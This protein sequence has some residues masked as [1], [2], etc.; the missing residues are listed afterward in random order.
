MSDYILYQQFGGLGDNL[1]FTT[2][3][4]RFNELGKTFSVSKTNE[5]INHEI[6]DLVWKKNPFVQTT[7]SELS[8]N[9]GSM[10]KNHR[11]RH[12]RNVIEWN[13]WR[14]DLE[15]LNT[16]PVIYYTPK[17]IP[18]AEDKILLDLGAGTC[19]RRKFY[20]I[21]RVLSLNNYLKSKT[22]NNLH[23]KSKYSISPI[24]KYYEDEENI[25]LDDI[26]HYCDLIY[27]CKKFICLYSGSS[28]L[29]SCIRKSGI[30]CIFP[31]IDQ[32]KEIFGCS[33]LFPNITYITCDKLFL[34]SSPDWRF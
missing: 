10:K 15:P 31:D 20:S 3:P 34:N 6:N 29:A 7:D 25:L 12:I 1:Q 19:F 30:L 2:L 14:H 4:K 24:T 32:K 5:L 26:F 33:Y 16:N 8:P 17:K 18:E 9:C 22:K 21:D 11:P 23:V 28:V 27:S 13:E